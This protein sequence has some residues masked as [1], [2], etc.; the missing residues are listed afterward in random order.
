ML[1]K[2][3]F[4]LESKLRESKLYLS[5][6]QTRRRAVWGFAYEEYFTNS[7]TRKRCFLYLIESMKEEQRCG[8]ER[9]QGEI[10]LEEGR[11]RCED[12]EKTAPVML[13]IYI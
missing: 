7:R 9:E 4:H 5:G 3:A 2:L 13:E 8:G 11:V 12:K 1:S 6:D 10:E